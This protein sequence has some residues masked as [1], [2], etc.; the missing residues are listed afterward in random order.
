MNLLWLI[1]RVNM[2][3][4][5]NLLL[6]VEV[7]RLAEVVL[8]LL[9]ALHVV[10]MSLTEHVWVTKGCVVSQLGLRNPR[11]LLLLRFLLLR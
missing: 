11:A 7:R 3:V 5:L 2:V 8:S 4:V 9:Y 6:T 10:V 1:V